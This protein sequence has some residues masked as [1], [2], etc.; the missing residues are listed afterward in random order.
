MTAI[1]PITGLPSFRAPTLPELAANL[2]QSARPAVTLPRPRTVLRLRA[3]AR[4]SGG[5]QSRVCYGRTPI[6]AM[7]LPNRL[8]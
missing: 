2:A 6:S 5:G 1:N 7:V 3:L 8:D 4:V